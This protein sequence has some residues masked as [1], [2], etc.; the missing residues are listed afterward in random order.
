MWSNSLTDIGVIGSELLPVESTD[1][2]HLPNKAE[3]Q[4]D[5]FSPPLTKERS[6]LRPRLNAMLACVMGDIDTSGLYLEDTAGCDTPLMEP[7]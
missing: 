7:K 4:D 2:R 1:Q 5:E 6:F 3:H